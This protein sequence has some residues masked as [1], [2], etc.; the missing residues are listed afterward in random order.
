MTGHQ[1]MDLGALLCGLLTAT[2]IG[3]IAIIFGLYAI[4]ERLR[5]DD[6]E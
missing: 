1:L 6:D 5:Q 2:G 3:G 4:E